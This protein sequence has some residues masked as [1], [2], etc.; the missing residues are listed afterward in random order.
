MTTNLNHLR[1]YHF[2]HIQTN[3]LVPTLLSG[4]IKISG[5]E[6][7][8]FLPGIKHHQSTIAKGRLRKH[9]VQ[10]ASRINTPLTTCNP[11]NILKCW[12]TLQRR[13]AQDCLANTKPGTRI[14]N[15]NITKLEN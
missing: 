3:S 15:A 2:L 8:E 6:V 5:I 13:S 7:T 14:T 10:W 11:M 1:Q 9:D 12:H 4:D